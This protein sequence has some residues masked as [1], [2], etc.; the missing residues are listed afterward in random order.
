MFS[1]DGHLGCQAAR[2]PLPCPDL[3]FQVLPLQD[4]PF[5]RIVSPSASVYIKGSAMYRVLVV[6]D[7][8]LISDMVARMLSAV[9]YLVSTA[10]NGSDALVQ[11]DAALPDL[12]LSDMQMPV[13]DGEA[14]Y[15]ALRTRGCDV[16][17]VGMS[18]NRE[19]LLTAG[20]DACLTKPFRMAELLITLDSV[21]T[22]QPVA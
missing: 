10:C 18:G 6:D 14:L 17:F 2:F 8:P 7:A 20:F 5:R 15:R 1:S 22:K 4:S 12:V 16:P 9:G 19:L 21:L 11:I 3:A 13:M